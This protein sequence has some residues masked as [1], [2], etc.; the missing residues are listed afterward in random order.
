MIHDFRSFLAFREEWIQL[1]KALPKLQNHILSFNRYVSSVNTYNEQI[2]LR[3]GE[4]TTVSPLLFNE[5]Y[6]NVLTELNDLFKGSFNTK[7][8]SELLR[9]DA[10]KKK[11]FTHVVSALSSEDV[12]M[13]ISEGKL[14]AETFQKLPYEITSADIQVPMDYLEN[15]DNYIQA[16]CNEYHAKLAEIYDALGY[17]LP[18]TKFRVEPL[19]GVTFEGRG[20][21]LLVLMNTL[22]D[23]LEHGETADV[24]K[25][26]EMG[27][28]NNY[29]TLELQQYEYEGEPAYR[30]LASI[31]GNKLFQKI[32][33]GVLAAD[34]AKEFAAM[35]GAQFI[36]KMNEI[37]IFDRM[38]SENTVKRTPY[39]KLDIGISEKVQEQKKT[40]DFE[41]EREI[42]E[43]LR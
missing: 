42:A 9:S 10:F 34:T 19:K 2:L 43:S 13:L 15:A 27:N 16:V 24:I 6:F 25:M 4:K 20:E 3:D 35:Q 29:V 26:S 33:I 36:C 11:L 39:M 40:R 14:S 30:V 28:L 17:Y 5:D 1:V 22:K 23:R 37:G 38:T 18:D 21:R 12:L 7:A 41:E 31:H 8:F 32:D